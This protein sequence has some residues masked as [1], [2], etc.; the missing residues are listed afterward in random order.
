MPC[1]FGGLGV[2]RHRELAAPAEF[3]CAA[4]T[5]PTV[6]YVLAQWGWSLEDCAAWSDHAALQAAALGL[7]DMGLAVT[8]KGRICKNSEV[9]VTL[10]PVQ[11]QLSVLAGFDVAPTLQSVTEI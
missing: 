10:L 5:A 11:F 1:K 3:A 2:P 8:D 9:V 7:D 4:Q 6:T